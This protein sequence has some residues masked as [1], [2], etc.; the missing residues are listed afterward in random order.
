MSVYV[1]PLMVWGGSNAPRCFRFKPSCH[2][3]ADDVKELH[4]LAKKI[5]LKR[6]WFQNKTLPHYDLTEG[7]RWQAVKHGAIEK[8][9]KHMV[10]YYKRS[11]HGNNR[12]Q[13]KT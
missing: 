11:K 8:D 5:G 12:K 1:D 4:K 7:K 2:M 10:R 13:N 3:Y 9:F 6:E